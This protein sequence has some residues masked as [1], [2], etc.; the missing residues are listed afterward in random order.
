MHGV[1]TV[2]CSCETR[3]C[4]GESTPRIEIRAKVGEHGVGEHGRG[5]NDGGW[6]E[7]K[8]EKGKKRKGSGV[9]RTAADVRG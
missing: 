3:L 2:I 6:Q 4:S 9:E 7:T 5:L 8:W 1:F